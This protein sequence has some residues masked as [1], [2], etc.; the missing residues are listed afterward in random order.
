M[1]TN[2]I[3]CLF[4]N[5]CR[6]PASDARFALVRWRWQSASQGQAS[7]PGPQD[8]QGCLGK[9]QEGPPSLGDPPI[10]SSWLSFRRPSGTLLSHA[11]FILPEAS[12]TPLYHPGP[13]SGRCRFSGLKLTRL[14]APLWQ[15]QHQIIS[16][17]CRL[18]SDCW[19]REKKS[20]ERHILNATQRTESK[21][22]T[23]AFIN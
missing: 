22:V 16:R 2:K 18:R 10:V 8:P 4:L 13:G 14:E 19:E 3:L 21:P 1:F 15:K 6:D 20:Q 11:T 5:L 9:A 23:S 7:L 17:G 12:L